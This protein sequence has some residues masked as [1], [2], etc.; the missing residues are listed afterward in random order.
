[1]PAVKLTSF[2]R[3]ESTYLHRSD[4][5]CSKNLTFAPAYPLKRRKA[6]LTGAE[7]GSLNHH[8]LGCRQL[9]I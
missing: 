3:R 6:L 1:M 5:L 7:K 8:F 2:G 9:N 4:D